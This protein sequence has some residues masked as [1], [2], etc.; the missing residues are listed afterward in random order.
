MTKSLAHGVG[1]E[2][3]LG[4]RNVTELARLAEAE[5]YASLWFN[6]HKWEAE[7]IEALQQ[8]LAATT[9]IEIGIGVFPLDAFPIGEIA[10]RLAA[11]GASTPRATIGIATGQIM[12][13]TLK[14]TEE[15]IAALRRALPEA[16]IATGGY[17]PKILE[18]GGRLSD[19]VLGNFMT[20]DR[21]RWLI[22]HVEAGAKAAGRKQP[23]IYLYHRAAQG[24]DAVERLQQE[25][26]NYRRYPVHQRHQESMGFP[27]RI[28]VAAESSADIA[29]QIAPYRG[30]GQVVLK[31]LPHEASNMEEW[32]SLLRFFAAAG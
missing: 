6:V 14:I 2:G 24:A 5:R 13:G 9:R 31:P 25:M 32:R 27:D 29:A 30:L 17:G 11:A 19:A 23:Q 7:P 20:P 8:A 12:Q 28:G 18:L 16:R 15:A 10:P 1:I 21:L 4:P 26:T 3:N 22:S